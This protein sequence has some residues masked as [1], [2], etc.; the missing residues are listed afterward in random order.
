MRIKVAVK[1]LIFASL[2]I[3]KEYHELGELKIAVAVYDYTGQLDKVFCLHAVAH[4]RKFGEVKE[5]YRKPRFGDVLPERPRYPCNTRR[6]ACKATH[7]VLCVFRLVAWVKKGE[8]LLARLVPGHYFLLPSG[9]RY[10]G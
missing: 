4:L 6:M 10:L 7:L 3:L 1:P 2:E 8:Y 9:Q 5:L